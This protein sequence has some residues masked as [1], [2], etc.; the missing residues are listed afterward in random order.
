MS[1]SRGYGICGSLNAYNSK[2]LLNN[3]NEDLI[4]KDIASKP[5]PAVGVYETNTMA[6]HCDPK[7]WPE[8]PPQ[9]NVPTPLELIIKNKEGTPY[10]LLFQHGNEEQPKQE[11]FESTARRTLSKFETFGPLPENHLNTERLK[12]I[13]REMK[14]ANVMTTETRSTQAYRDAG[15]AVPQRSL[16]HSDPLP[17]WRRQGLLTNTFPKH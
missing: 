13:K 17:V 7:L 2:V 10:M 1:K 3:W 11:R 14:L 6:T 8:L 9:E 16:G 15:S 12:K 5:R 4:G